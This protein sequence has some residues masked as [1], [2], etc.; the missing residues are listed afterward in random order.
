MSGAFSQVHYGSFGVESAVCKA[1]VVSN[2]VSASLL[3]QFF[4]I[5]A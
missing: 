1:V 5:S 4:V 2:I 3:G